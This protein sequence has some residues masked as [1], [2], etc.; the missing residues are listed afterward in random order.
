MKPTLHSFFA[1][2][3]EMFILSALLLIGGMAFSQASAPIKFGNS[4][5]NLSKKKAG[6]TVQPGDTLEIR[7]NFYVNSTYDGPGI[8]YYLR[9]YDN[10]PTKTDTVRDSL[11][12]ITNEGVTFRKYTLAA[13]DDAGSFVPVPAF[14]GDYQIRINMGGTPGGAPYPE[15]AATGGFDPMG[16]ANITGASHL[17]SGT[18]RPKFSG[19]AIITTSFRVKVTGNYGDTIILGAGK[20][21]YRTSLTG[22][23]TTLNAN[24][25]KI[26]ISKPITL[27]ASTVG[28]NFA[29]ESGG[30]FGHGVGRNRAAPPTYLIPNYT[31]LP[32]SGTTAGNTINDGYYAIVN[33]ISP[34]SSTFPGANR[35][36]TCGALPNTSPNSCFNREFGGFW[37][38]SGDHS[39]TT[40]A[41]GN[42][43]PDNNTDAGYM[44]L[45]NADLAT[46]EAYRQT[47]TGLCPN[48]YYQFYA[49]IKNVCPNCGIDSFGNQ[50]YTP[51][52]LPN[53][54]FV[55]DSLDRYSS[56]QVDT[57][58]W[59]QRGFVLKT[60]PTQTS[61]TISLRNNAPGGGGNDWALDDI[62]L[63]N[64][65]PDIQLTPNKP[66]TLCQGA[67]DTVRFKIGAY[68]DNYTQWMLQKSIDGG[69]TWTAAGPDTLN[70]ADNGTVVPVFNPVTGQYADTVVR[71]FRL[72]LVD[73]LII[74][75]LVVAT[76]VANLSNTNC[77]FITSTP[78]IIHAVNCNI[79]LPTY[80]ISFKGQLKGG[81]GNLQWIS[82]D[83]TTDIVYNIERSDDGTTFHAIGSVKGFAGAG[84]GAG[85]RFTDPTPVT[86]QT[87]YRINIQSAGLHQYSNLVL[88]SNTDINFDI[89]SLVNPFTDHITMDLLVPADGTA[90][91]NVID[92]YGR[93]LR[94]ERQP[95]TQGLNSL[96]I[97]GLGGLPTGTY[98]LQIRYN[99]KTIS[100]K[101]VKLTK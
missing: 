3:K 24:Q 96:G 17:K 77:N 20:I 46:S 15:P 12:L 63:A 72:N 35:Q 7:T 44:L 37:F 58:G 74:Y 79:I 21:V 88:L 5:V 36:P 42:P 81:L 28:T 98:I 1:Y 76:T 94:Q 59:Q 57:I 52:V 93:F 71:Y 55:V 84:Q 80:L 101:I 16:L 29:A 87:W 91:L 90:Q 4:Y 92:M 25:Y 14:A 11:R 49:W 78:K 2:C 99:D 83:E 56:G 48:T 34:T 95:V 65:P 50:T 22:A 45:V 60:G 100:R 10:L 53:L 43:P 39:G 54:T 26:L 51:G 67:D 32:N 82:A 19:G 27:C 69:S 61:I 41:A 85:Y 66:D 18:S 38:I 23:D 73:N 9:Y 97:F 6:G 33:N 30:T 47:I 75:R 31:Y 68:V 62:A 64:C 8:M 89:R 70:R 13:G 40:T 86:T